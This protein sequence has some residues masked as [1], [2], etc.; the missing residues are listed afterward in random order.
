MEAV[1]SEG[2]MAAVAAGVPGCRSSGGTA[3]GLRGA[4][5]AIEDVETRCR[6]G[7]AAMPVA[8]S[9]V[10][11]PYGRRERFQGASGTA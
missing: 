9:Q 7:T 5:V 8:A 2:A 4:V 6:G 3:S 1:M 11:V 10:A